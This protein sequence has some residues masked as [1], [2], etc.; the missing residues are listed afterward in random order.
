[1]LSDTE[2]QE[3]A[4]DLSSPDVSIRVE[5][6]K[7]LYREPAA[8]ERVLP[9]LENLL[10]DDTISVIFLP[11]RFGEVRW[12]AAKALVAERAALGHSQPICLDNVFQPINIEEFA[13]LAHSAGIKSSGGLDGVLEA[14]VILR[15]MNRLPLYTLRL[16]PSSTKNQNVKVNDLN[17]IS[18]KSGNQVTDDKVT[19]VR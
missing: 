9:Y 2:F 18:D 13:L 12:L 6:L 11:Y 7:C 4:E 17:P 3:L 8:D 15:K 16:V 5:T 1:M 14:L 19:R 10:D